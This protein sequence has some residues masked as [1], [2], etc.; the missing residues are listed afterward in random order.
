MSKLLMNS[1]W[2]RHAHD[3]SNSKVLYFT[4]PHEFYEML[5]SPK[6]ELD[7]LEIVNDDMIRVTVRPNED[8][9]TPNGQGSVI[10]SVF[11]TSY[12]RLTIYDAMKRVSH[13]CCY[14]DT[15]GVIYIQGVESSVIPIGIALG[16]FKNELKDS[17]ECIEVYAGAGLKSYAFKT[18][19]GIVECKPK[20][21]S[22]DYDASKQLKLKS[23]I[24]LVTQDENMVTTVTYPS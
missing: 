22:L 9:Q 21:I 13:N 12:G 3:E 14:V 17:S 5:N 16:C 2:G 8:F 4:K 15:D 18:R 6:F 19:K 7:N 23:L 1:S 11:T 10:Y 24:Q 20:D